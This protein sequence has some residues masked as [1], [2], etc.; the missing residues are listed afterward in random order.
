MNDESKYAL[1]KLKDALVK[2]RQGSKEA[3]T[4]LERDGVIQRSIN[5]HLR[6][7]KPYSIMN[8]IQK[9]A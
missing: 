9:Y 5:F 3:K 7:I 6:L 4:E 8:L 1:G 2:L